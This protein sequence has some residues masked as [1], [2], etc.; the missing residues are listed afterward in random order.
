[1]L[2]R[3]QKIMKIECLPVSKL[4]RRTILQHHREAVISFSFLFRAL[5]LQSK[6]LATVLNFE[7]GMV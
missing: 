2:I 1:M 4:I 5:S 7:Y 6:L 3:F